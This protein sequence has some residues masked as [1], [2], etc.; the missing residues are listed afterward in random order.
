[1]TSKQKKLIESAKPYQS[2]IALRSIYIINSGK[3]YNGTWGKNGYR[4]IIVLGRDG[5]NEL[6]NIK[7]DQYDILTIEN[8]YDYRLKFD[9]ESENDCLRMWVLPPYKIA[10][11]MD[12]ISNLILKVVKIGE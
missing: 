7:G 8:E 6:Y 1:M 9:I 4:Q 11:E 3:D 2:G 10:V 12:Y 5:N